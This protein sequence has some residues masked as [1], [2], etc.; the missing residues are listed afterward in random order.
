MSSLHWYTNANNAYKIVCVCWLLKKLETAWTTHGRPGR[1]PYE[2]TCDGRAD[3]CDRF[4][5]SPPLALTETAF[6][7]R[8]VLLSFSSVR[9][10]WVHHIWSSK[11]RLKSRRRVLLSFGS[12]SVW[13]TMSIKY[14]ERAARCWLLL[15]LLGANFVT[16]YMRPTLTH[17]GMSPMRVRATALRDQVV[18]TLT[19]FWWWIFPD[20]SLPGQHQIFIQVDT[21]FRGLASTHSTRVNRVN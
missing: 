12:G 16:N 10:K 1:L 17:C 4:S 20:R 15:T 5:V 14:V 19:L 18:V 11:M 3:F 21:Y 6:T 2:R 13:P 9:W 8:R 7:P